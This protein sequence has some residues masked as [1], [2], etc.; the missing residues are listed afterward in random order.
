MKRDCLRKKADNA[1]GSKKPDG[2]RREGGGG[3]SAPPGAALA[4]DASAGQ[5][6]KLNATGSTSWSST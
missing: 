2:G 4:Y 6:A 5:T 1:K 3:R